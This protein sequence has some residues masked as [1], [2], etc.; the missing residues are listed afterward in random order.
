[1]PE[2][3]P[4]GHGFKYLAPWDANAYFALPSQ[5]TVTPGAARKMLAAANPNRVGMILSIGNTAGAVGFVSPV[6]PTSGGIT[7]NSSTP[8]LIVDHEHW[9]VWCQVQWDCFAAAGINFSVIELILLKWPSNEGGGPSLRQPE[10]SKQGP[11]SPSAQQI[12][13]L[14]DRIQNDAD[15]LSRLLAQTES[16]SV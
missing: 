3:I 9:G 2:I 12:R 1:M 10:L 14:L 5:T 15:L 6:D 11:L 4:N 16:L 8:F 13:R 7:L